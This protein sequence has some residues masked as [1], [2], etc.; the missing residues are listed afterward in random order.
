MLTPNKYPP[1]ETIK[2]G[3]IRREHFRALLGN[4]SV[5]TFYVWIA[6]GIIPKPV[7]C[8]PRM[9]LWPAAQVK[10]TLEKIRNGGLA[11]QTDETAKP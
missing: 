4:P 7:K 2:D 5:A 10:E 6:S 1:L 11:P 3:F 8:G 9:V